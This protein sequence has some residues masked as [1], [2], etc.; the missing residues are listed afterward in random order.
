MVA[1]KKKKPA[2]NPA[3]G[4]A[5]T[6]VAS[7]PK[8][9]K[10]VDSAE[11]SETASIAADKSGGSA[12]PEKGLSRN[13]PVKELHELNPEEL[14]EQLEQNELQMLVEKHAAKV[15]REAARL[16]SRV[17]TDRRVLRTQAEYLR[18][19]E[20]L[21]EELMLQILDLAKAEAL[22]DQNSDNKSLPKAT[23]EED[24]IIK[25]WTLYQALLDLGF[26]EERVRYVLKQLCKNPPKVEGGSQPWGFAESLDLLVLESDNEEL[27]DYDS[28]R[29]RPT[30]NSTDDS[31]PSKSIFHSSTLAYHQSPVFLL[32]CALYERQIGRPRL[33]T[34][35]TPP[36]SLSQCG[37][38]LHLKNTLPKAVCSFLFERFYIVLLCVET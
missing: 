4:F 31:R 3:R 36:N 14:E 5:T 21:P 25:L 13:E 29:L 35:I 17:Q 12:T 28:F 34:G 2:A 9:D 7:K 32:C 20:W 11:A 24:G 8:V 30:G 33:H 22:E 10:A 27:K 6:S 16:Q 19:S 15:R 23:T 26:S 38:I 1:K 37:I 18:T